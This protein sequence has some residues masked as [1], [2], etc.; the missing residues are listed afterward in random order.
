MDES[1]I[2]KADIP[3]TEDGVQPPSSGGDKREFHLKGSQKDMIFYVCMI[4]WAVIQFA[5]CYVWVNVSSFI[6]AFQ[7]IN[8]ATGDISWTFGNF[9]DIFVELS[10]PNFWTMTKNSV[11]A[12]L[13]SLVVSIPLGL[14]FSYYIY[15]KMPGSI[16]FRAVLFMPSIVSAIVMVT[17]FRYFVTSAMPD[18]MNDLFGVS[19]PNVLDPATGHAFGTVMFYSIWVGFGT[20]VLMYS[21][22]MS[23][24]DPELVDAVHIDGANGI[25]E[26]WHISLPLVF[27]TLSVFLITGVASIFVNQINLY[28]FYGGTAHA[29]VQTFGYYLYM[30]TRQADGDYGSYPR[31][32]AFGLILTAV[33]IP[34]TLLVRWLLEKFGPS[35]D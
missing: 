31:L 32:A 9:G 35:E 27:P 25:R 22:G 14:L 33:A 4:A 28:S 7:N 24:I 5:V 18:L 29:S 16:F 34:L 15:K 30:A 20:S 1:R 2:T 6:M 23:G 8:V 19:M 3:V 12:W 21:N 10:W 17:M 11:L 26:F 13:L